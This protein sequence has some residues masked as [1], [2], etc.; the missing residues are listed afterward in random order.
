MILQWESSILPTYQCSFAFGEERIL[1]RLGTAVSRPLSNN[2][3]KGVFQF[4]ISF[5]T[6]VNQAAGKRA[7]HE[8]FFID[9]TAAEK[10]SNKVESIKVEEI[11]LI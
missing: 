10:N 3:S 2:E 5:K 11:S 1:Q 7:K 8:R 4:I 6:R 9:M